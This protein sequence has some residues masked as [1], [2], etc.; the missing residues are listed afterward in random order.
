M[1]T[2]DQINCKRPFRII[3]QT[4]IR[5]HGPNRNVRI[6]LVDTATTNVDFKPKVIVKFFV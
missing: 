4:L 1:Q 5:P 3:F 2:N 6:S